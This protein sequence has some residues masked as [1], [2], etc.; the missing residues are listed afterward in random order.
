MELRWK[1][2][3]SWLLIST[4]SSRAPTLP[5]AMLTTGVGLA[6]STRKMV[7]LTSAEEWCSVT[8]GRSRWMSIAS[9]RKVGFAPP[10]THVLQLTTVFFAPSP[11]SSVSFEPSLITVLGRRSITPPAASATRREATSLGAWRPGCGVSGGRYAMGRARTDQL[12]WS[13]FRTSTR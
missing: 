8:S 13:S 7:T 6:Q 12:A 2:G 10:V 9:Q 1:A 11:M 5:S 4:P 3:L